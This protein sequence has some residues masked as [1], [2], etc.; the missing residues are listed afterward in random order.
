MCTLFAAWQQ[1]PD[2]PLLIAANRDENLARPSS[3]PKLWPGTLPF[4]APVDDQAGGSWVGLN[5]RGVFVAITNR[6]LTARYPERKSRG[7]IVTHALRLPTAEAVAA[8]LRSIDP[9][10]YNAFHLLYADAHHAF[11]SW[12][13]GERFTHEQLTPGLHVV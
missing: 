3:P 5:A 2:F 1:H 8:H 9:R 12:T 10:D 11:V 4:L 7:E 13:D 6:Y